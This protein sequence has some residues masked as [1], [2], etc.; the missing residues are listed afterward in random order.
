[1]TSPQEKPSILKVIGRLLAGLAGLVLILVII[2]LVFAPD[3]ARKKT[4]AGFPVNS[5]HYLPLNEKTHV[6]I[7]A[8]L[9]PNLKKDEKIPALMTASRY[10]GQLEPGWLAK[11]LETY[12]LSTNPNFRAARPNHDKGYA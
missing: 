11:V 8:W 12:S 6:W 4:P 7:S 1:M 2:G 10:S 3:Y 9:P 5:T